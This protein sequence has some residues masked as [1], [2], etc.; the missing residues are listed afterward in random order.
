MDINASREATKNIEE[1][2]SE[3]LELGKTW[4]MEILKISQS[5][6]TNFSQVLQTKS[7]FLQKTATKIT[8]HP[9]L[10]SILKES[11]D[12]VSP[13]IYLNSFQ[14]HLLLDNI[15]V[16]HYPHKSKLY[17]PEDFEQNKNAFIL[18]KGEA[19]IYNNEGTFEDLMSNVGIFGYDGPIFQTR[20]K[21]CVLND[22]TYIGVIDEKVF[23]DLIVPFSKYCMYLS[24]NIIYK[25]KTLDSLNNLKTYI[26]SMINKGPLNLKDLIEKYKKIDSCLHP[27]CLSEEMDFNAWSY[28]L[29][30]LPDNIFETLSLV[31]INVAPKILTL[32]EE[33]HSQLL[34][35]IKTKA[36]M[37]DTF[38]YLDGKNIIYVRELETDVLDFIANMCIHVVEC[39][40]MRKHISSPLI[41]EKLFYAKNDF[42]N[43]VNIL[44]SNTLIQINIEDEHV[45]S[46]AFGDEF[47]TKL[48][49]IM[50]HYQDYSIQINKVPQNNLDSVECW[51]QNLWKH[52]KKLLDIES[53]VDEIDD[54]VVDII[55]GSKR[56]LIGC[57]SPHLHKNA[58]EILKWGEETNV[59]LQTKI[60]L[61]EI[62][63]LLAVAY[64]YY[65]AFPEKQKE[66]EE[67]ES[68]HGIQTI[69]ETFGTG[70]GVLLVNVNKLDPKFVDPNLVHKAASK[71]HLILHIGYTFGAQS[72][73]II[74]P[75]LMLFG[76]KARSMNIIGKAGGLSGNRTDI[77]IA[78]KMFYDKTHELCT[79]NCGKIN[80]EELMKETKSGVH[81]GPMLTV[82]GT[83]LQNNDLLHFY[84][85][86]MGCIGLEMEGFFFIKEIDNSIKHGLLRSDFITRCFYYASDLP[87]DPTQNLSMEDGNVSWDEGVG[88]MNAIMRY[89]F[90]QIFSY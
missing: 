46:K 6:K 44:K 80:E 15:K 25:D 52:A 55:Q 66:R 70:I 39:F 10:L 36:R 81:L 22:N 41:L 61:N 83:I 51:T 11:F 33:V 68:Q 53:S 34:K 21:I 31:M 57:I 76:S 65:K 12:T 17:S 84:K 35:P 89:I 45:L 32:P 86:V 27:K 24:K 8:D 60:F 85:Y 3:L 77:L 88:S 69:L 58:K 37:R 90:K 47:A 74:K 13:L 64:Y 5:K 48:I 2:H 87:L 38:K 40:K 18:L 63:K 19:H 56:T 50:L 82:A 16:M 20:T 78:N 49:N 30:R 7:N 71:N 67:A 4:S 43:T 29:N 62:D 9:E 75:L 59:K 54:L 14:R 79:I 23:L 28:S 73:A 42:K 72:S 26:L 1:G